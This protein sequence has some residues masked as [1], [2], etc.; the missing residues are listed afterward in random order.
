MRASKKSAALP[1]LNLQPCKRPLSAGDARVNESV[2]GDHGQHDRN[3]SENVFRRNVNSHGAVIFHPAGSRRFRVK[4]NLST[5]SRT[6][7]LTANDAALDQIVSRLAEA[8]H[9]ERIW[10]FGLS[11][12]HI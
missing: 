9:P 8:Y 5:M 10:L 11:L 4:L 1:L 3:D 12:I 6:S 7:L 2:R